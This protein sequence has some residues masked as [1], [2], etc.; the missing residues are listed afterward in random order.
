MK[1]NILRVDLFCFVKLTTF[2]EPAWP[3]H[4]LFIFIFINIKV[5]LN[6]LF[7][8]DLI[9]VVRSNGVYAWAVETFLAEKYDEEHPHDPPTPFYGY[10]AYRN[11][12]RAYRVMTNDLLERISV[13][14]Q[15]ENKKRVFLKPFSDELS[16][17]E[18][19]L[20]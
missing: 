20:D 9:W 18:P 1:S 13:K 12:E 14:G 5:N 4:H 2:H 7:S 6:T 10:H 11:L 16:W 15:I 3:N 8:L 17:A 19:G